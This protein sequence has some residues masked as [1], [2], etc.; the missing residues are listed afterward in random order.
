MDDKH[1]IIDCT[2]ISEPQI[3]YTTISQ[4][5]GNTTFLIANGNKYSFENEEGSDGWKIGEKCKVIIQDG[6]LLEVNS[7]TL[8]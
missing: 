3:Y 4:I 6:R 1:D 5:Q 7:M 8:C 2:V